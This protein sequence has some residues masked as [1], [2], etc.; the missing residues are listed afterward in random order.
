MVY[1]IWEHSFI[2]GII[3]VPKAASILTGLDSKEQQICSYLDVVKQMKNK[4]QIL[5]IFN[6]KKVL[7]IF[8][9]MHKFDN[10]LFFK[11]QFKI[12]KSTI[13]NF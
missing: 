9:W 11:I 2:S 10:I 12:E 13:N 5:E 4:H 7:N 6:C 8:R 3:N 1:L